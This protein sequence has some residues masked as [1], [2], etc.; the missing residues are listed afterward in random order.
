VIFRAFPHCG[1]AKN[2]IIFAL[3][4]TS[5]RPVATGAYNSKPAIYWDRFY[6]LNKGSFVHF[7]RFKCIKIRRSSV[8]L[9]SSFVSLDSTCRLW[10][11]SPV[12]RSFLPYLPMDFQTGYPLTSLHYDSLSFA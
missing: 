1:S 6:N 2:R 3:I 11:V 8:I 9:T 12:H 7:L 4:I 10:H 5:L